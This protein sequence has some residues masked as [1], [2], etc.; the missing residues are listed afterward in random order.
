[1]SSERL[2][3]VSLTFEK[4]NLETLVELPTRKKPFKKCDSATLPQCGKVL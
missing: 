4:S 2:S 3:L 1:M